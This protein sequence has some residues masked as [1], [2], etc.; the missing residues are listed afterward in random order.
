MGSLFLVFSLLIAPGLWEKSGTP[1]YVGADHTLPDPAINDYFEP[2]SHRTGELADA[3]G[4]R[5]ECGLHEERRTINAPQGRLG[6]SLYYATGGRRAAVILIHGNDPETRE[7]GFIIPYFVCNGLNV[8]SYDQRGTGDSIGN[9]FLNGPVQKADDVAVIYDAFRAD[10]HVDSRRIGVWAFSNGG[11]S[12]PLVTLRRPIAFMLL[13]SAPTESLLSNIHF[14][15][16]TE[17]RYHGASD[18]QIAQALVMWHTVEG[19][20]YGTTSWSK[21]ITVLKP[22][23]KQPWFQHSLMLNFSTP[24]P[25]ALAEGLRRAITY[26]PYETLTHTTTPALAMYG[27][28]DQ[29]VES[30]DS[31]THMKAYLRS[32]GDRDVTV[33]MFPRASHMLVITKNGFDPEPPERYA[34]G[35]PEIMI[36]W[37]R[38]RGFIAQGH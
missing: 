37:L 34:A 1:I 14:E 24:P 26:D 22:D 35:Y 15:V 2:V 3:Q 12:A 20:L 19:A 31:Y 4:L 25:Q 10:P 7:M 21:A 18:A 9:W 5:L 16:Q 29:K 32:A 36:A 17:M 23:E 13:K 8:I 30:A 27:A 28:R 6:A 11:W 38:Q 33:I